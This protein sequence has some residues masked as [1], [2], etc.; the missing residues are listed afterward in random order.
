MSP[1]RWF[2][3]RA[4][5]PSCREQE[6]FEPQ[7]HPGGGAK[8]A[9]QQVRQLRPRQPDL[10]G[11]VLLGEAAGLDL[12]S[13]GSPDRH[14][15]DATSQ[16]DSCD[17]GSAKGASPPKVKALAGTRAGRRARAPPPPTPSPLC[18]TVPP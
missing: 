1:R 7:G 13:E 5:R 11:Q 16:A 2:K 17:A 12:V 18:S 4:T 15:R 3:I 14:R 8:S 9:G 6:C 10:T